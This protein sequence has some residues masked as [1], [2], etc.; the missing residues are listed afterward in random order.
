MKTLHTSVAFFYPLERSAGLL[1]DFATRCPHI[2]GQH[3]HVIYPNDVQHKL[4]GCVA[5]CGGVNY[6]GV[7]HMH[8]G[9]ASNMT[10]ASW[11]T[12]EVKMMQTHRQ[13]LV[14]VQPYV[15]E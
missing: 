11:A 1:F 7:V 2:V 3:D 8:H 5:W 9:Q 12:D 10:G 6:L 14:D 13:R 4:R 15:A